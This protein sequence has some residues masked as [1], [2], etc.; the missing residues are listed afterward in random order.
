MC[1]KTLPAVWVSL[2]HT[3]S[4]SLYTK[5]KRRWEWD[6][7][8]NYSNLT[9]AWK[10]NGIRRTLDMDKGGLQLLAYKVSLIRTQKPWLWIHALQT[11]SEYETINITSNIFHQ[12]TQYWIRKLHRLEWNEKTPVVAL[13]ECRLYRCTHKKKHTSPSTLYMY[14]WD[15]K[16]QNEDE[17]RAPM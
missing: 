17:L 6:K 7:I 16:F 8:S 1:N 2:L 10:V 14:S 15:M 3:D 4:I 12:I 11:P 5:V 9:A 13:Q